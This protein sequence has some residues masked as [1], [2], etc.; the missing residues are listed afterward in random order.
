MAA[1]PIVEYP[2]DK[3]ELCIFNKSKAIQKALFW[4]LLIFFKDIQVCLGFIKIAYS[5]NNKG[6]F[7]QK[8]CCF[9]AI[10]DKI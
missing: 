10:P 4:L 9:P 6:S 8:S 7:R 3:R 2:H 1:S 5:I